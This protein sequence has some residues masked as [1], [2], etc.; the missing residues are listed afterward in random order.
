M[1]RGR[2]SCVEKADASR[3]ACHSCNSAWQRSRS[4]IEEESGWHTTGS[5][6]LM[7]SSMI[8]SRQLDACARSAN[9]EG[10]S[11]VLAS[12]SGVERE[13][14]PLGICCGRQYSIKVAAC[15]QH[16]SKAGII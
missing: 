4:I 3:A 1:S 11:I 8:K 15:L 7:L 16:A 10:T 6:S 12:A 13:N 2:F 14:L 9:F 5:G